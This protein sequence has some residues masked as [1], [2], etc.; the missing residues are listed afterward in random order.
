MITDELKTNNWQMSSTQQGQ[1]ITDVEDISQCILN[2]INTQKGSDPVNPLFGIDL[3]AYIDKPAQ[4]V[5]PVLMKDVLK[6]IT[7][8]EPRVTVDLMS[9]SIIDSNIIITVNWSMNN[10]TGKISQAYATT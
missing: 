4:Q 9:N 8:F 6:Q 3:M 7:I 2:I 1:V 10:I 5:A